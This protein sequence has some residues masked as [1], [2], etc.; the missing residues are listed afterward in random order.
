MTTSPISSQENPFTPEN[1]PGLIFKVD[2]KNA[3][4]SHGNPIFL[5]QTSSECPQDVGC[6]A[7]DRD[8]ELIE[9]ELADL[10]EN[11]NEVWPMA[12][13]STGFPYRVDPKYTD[14]TDWPDKG[15]QATFTDN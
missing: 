10:K 8:R 5:V 7:L 1:Y 14:L 13:W 9:K 12:P 4:C 15:K 2:G 11:G 3:I 6:Y